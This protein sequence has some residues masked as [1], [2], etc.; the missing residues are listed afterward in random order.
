MCGRRAAPT[1]CRQAGTGRKQVCRS[2]A[3]DRAWSRGSRCR[4]ST[5]RCRAGS[6]CSAATK[7]SR[8]GSRLAASSAYSGRRWSQSGTT[9]CEALRG[10]RS[11]LGRA[12]RSRAF[13]GRRLPPRTATRASGSSS[14]LA[15]VDAAQA[16][17]RRV[18]HPASDA[19]SSEMLRPAGWQSSSGVRSRLRARS[20]WAR[21]FLGLRSHHRT[22]RDRRTHRYG[23]AGL[24]PLARPAHDRRG[25][26]THHLPS[27]AVSRRVSRSTLR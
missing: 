12:R 25:V 19:P 1:A 7:A 4:M 2:R 18:R 9:R 10:P 16:Q 21:S 14:R 15:L 8:I 11:G 27:S 13:P 20:R 6:R 3:A 22:I 26:L 5:A 17:R 23:G 24:G